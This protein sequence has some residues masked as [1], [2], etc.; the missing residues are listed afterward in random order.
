M[1]KLLQVSVKSMTSHLQ[2]KHIAMLNSPSLS[3]LATVNCDVYTYAG[4]YH[5][6]AVVLATALLTVNLELKLILKGCCVC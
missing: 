1:S 5:T 6:Q 3:I 2:M 4:S